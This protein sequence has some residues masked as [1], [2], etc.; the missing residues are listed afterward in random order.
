MGTRDAEEFGVIVERLVGHEC[1]RT[2]ATNSIKLRFDTERDPRGLRYIWIEPPWTLYHGD[3]V[4]TTS[5]EYTDE[6]FSAWNRHLDPLNRTTFV[7]WEGR[8]D[9]TAFRFANEYTVFVPAGYG[10]REGNVWF[11]RW[12]AR[13]KIA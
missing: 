11:E 7:G 6:A 12:Y 3:L 9:G 13:E 5:D 10:D 1:E 8:D 2:L 4:I